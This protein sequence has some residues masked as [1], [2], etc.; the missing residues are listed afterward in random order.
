M[1]FFIYIFAVHLKLIIM[2]FLK[3]IIGGALILA[4]QNINAQNMVIDD[5]IGVF[6]GPTFMQTDYGE[7]HQ[8]DSSINNT[9]FGFGFAYIADFSSSRTHSN[10][11]RM[12]SE[13]VKLRVELS[14]VK[15][16][17]SYDGRPVEVPNV[18][19]DRFKAMEG[20]TKLLNLGLF[21]EIYLKNIVDEKKLQPYMLL[22]VSISSV[23]PSL[24]SSLALPNIYLPEEE[25]V[26]MENQTVLS[27]TGGLGT[28]Y[29]LDDVD[30]VFE[31]RFN[32]F[33]SD[34][35]EGLDSN[36][37]ADKNNDTQTIF[38]LGVVFKLN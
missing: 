4:T 34:K 12:F 3:F 11:G 17:F 26:F 35:V 14:Y 28:R 13:H 5:E 24:K 37:P 22:G 9:G 16:N 18:Q 7:A 32:A 2:K 8:F 23:K 29:R 38:N 15:A 27:F 31:Y 33:M 36:I 30:I 6:L 20:S 10:F 1:F 19:Q 25:N 21:S